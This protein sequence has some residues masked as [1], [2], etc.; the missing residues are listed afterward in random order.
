MS[1]L[2]KAVR[3]A[4]RRARQPRKFSLGYISAA[5]TVAGAER[6]G[7][8]LCDYVEKQWGSEGC[9]AQIVAHMQSSGAFAF[10]KPHIV[11]IGAGTGRY[12]EKVLEKSKPAQYEIYETAE[13]WAEW[14]SSRYPII[15]HRA[16]GRSLRATKTG[17]VDLLHAHGVF[18]YLPLLVSYGY[19]KEIWRVMRPHGL[20]VFDIFSEACLDEL[21]LE[22]WLEAGDIYPAFLS[23]SFTV[24][25]FERHGFALRATFVNHCYGAGR[26]E[27]LVLVRS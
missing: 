8:S 14:L 24:A 26:S 25:H 3:T 10:A 15:S 22:R 27:Y 21:T 19:W 16:D 9:T 2:M 12:L 17:S 13:D 23:A 7:L 20:V 1:T 5:D 11:E 18:V 4:L 6:E